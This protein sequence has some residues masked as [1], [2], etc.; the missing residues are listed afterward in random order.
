MTPRL[1]NVENDH[2]P[3]RSL[4]QS[5]VLHGTFAR[6]CVVL[7]AAS[8]LFLTMASIPEPAHAVDKLALRRKQIDQQRARAMA[9]KL[10]SSAVDLQIHQLEDNGLTEL[11]IYKEIVS[12]RGSIGEL[13]E[14]EMADVVEILLDAQ[15]LD[16]AAERE[17]KFVAA[18]TTI[19]QIVIRLAVERHNLLR[20][21]RNAEIAEQIKRLITLET[22]AMTVTKG[23]PEESQTRREQLAV[24]TIEDQRDIK[25]LFL[26]LVETL[27]DVSS[28][29]GAIG[30]GATKGLVILKR[31]EV[32]LHLD[33]AGTELA[34]TKF[35]SSAVE[36]TLVVA[37][38]KKLLDEVLHTQG[39]ISSDSESIFERI[40]EL[41]NRQ[42]EVRAKVQKADLSNTE[43]ST[44]LTTEQDAIKAEL[45]ELAEAVADNPQAAEHVQ[46]AI[47]AAAK[48]TEQI[49]SEEPEQAVNAQRLVEGHLAALQD[50]LQMDV[51]NQLSDR[52]AAELAVT[53]KNLEATKTELEAV[54]RQQDEVS[55]TAQQ[56]PTKAAQQEK[57]VEAALAAVK[58]AAA[59]RKLPEELEATLAAA[60][61]AVARAVAAA[62]KAAANKDSTK[63]EDQASVDEAIQNADDAVERA[64][65]STQE[66]LAE[67][68]RMEAAVKIGE[69]ARAAEA[70]ERAAAAERKIA[71][72]TADIAQGKAVTPEA[73]V[74]LAKEQKTV[75]EVAERIAE[76]VKETSPK[77]SEAL[78]QAGAKAQEA[79]APLGQLADAAKQ[80]DATVKA[81][82]SATA[83]KNESAM[84]AA[85][86]S[87]ADAKLK[88]GKAGTQAAQKATDAAGQLAS[89]AQ[90]LRN[91][92][93]STAQK[94][95]ELS[96]EQLAKVAEAQAAVDAT[97]QGAE[98][99]LADR[100]GQLSAA[101]NQVAAAF[102]DQ[103]RAEGRP[104]AAAA[105]DLAR[106]IAEVQAAQKT[107]D[108]A[109]AKAE[110]G[111]SATPLEAA[112][113]QLAVSDAAQ[114][115][116]KEATERTRPDAAD[117]SKPSDELTAELQK[118]QQAGAEAARQAL[119]GNA[120]Q[121][122]A[123][124]QQAR[125]ALAKALQ[126][127]ITEADAAAKAEPTSKPDKQAQEA[128]AA[129]AQA[130]SE[131][132]RDDAGDAAES[133]DEATGSAQ[134]AAKELGEELPELAQESQ[135][136]T[137]DS[138]TEAAKTLDKAARDLAGQQATEL[139]DVGKQADN[140]ARKAA[141]VDA[142][143]TAAIRDA[144]QAAKTAEKAA[145]AVAA[146]PPHKN[147][148]DAPNSNRDL[149]PTDLHAA[150]ADKEIGEN[151]GRAAADLAA[152]AQQLE[153]EQALAQ[154]LA[155]LAKSQHESVTQIADARDALKEAAKVPTATGQ[156]K[157][158]DKS[159]S[160]P[161]GKPEA[162]KAPKGEASEMT[163]DQES[164][165]KKLAQA[166]KQFSN[167]Q[168][169]TGEGAVEL[170]GQ[171]EVANQPI[172][173]ALDLASELL[174]ELK[175]IPA[176]PGEQPEQL[177]AVAPEATAAPEANRSETP[178]AD[179]ASEP[180]GE[181]AENGEP[182]G[183]EQ[184]GSQQP[185]KNPLG[186]PQSGQP[187]GSQP[188]SP[189]QG[190]P[191]SAQLGTGFVP[192]SPE[193][194]ARLMADPDLLKQLSEMLQAAMA[195]AD[196]N[197]DAAAAQAA[198]SESGQPAATEPPAGQSPST[199][200]P[201]KNAQASQK[202]EGG[203]ESDVGLPTENQ[204]TKDDPLNVVDKATPSKD[205]R[206]ATSNDRNRTIES[207]E[208]R[209]AA[210]FAK[211]PAELRNAILAGS[212][213]R[214]PRAYE[215][216]LRR[217]FESLE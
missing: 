210:W 88:A 93:A 151:L 173:E 51:A 149:A 103:Q 117:K 125:N 155:E 121:A 154:A 133:L 140:A 96:G 24:R 185:G 104:E 86:K 52:T 118:A 30:Q 27:A 5:A 181:A 46:E 138:L 127:A 98:K 180:A 19:R 200:Q 44:A 209:Q 62:L 182:A 122:E 109:A 156:D 65:A 54:A 89:A 20:R 9:Q 85:Q 166:M 203:G 47:E 99:S 67:A 87:M 152:R 12:M 187:N 163:P 21:L 73:A 2:E 81:H 31:E 13:V 159:N 142:S 50:K 204:A 157:S 146:A 177:A 198:A 83:Q 212:Q 16:T 202:S 18:R 68:Q 6:L 188:G 71:E 215:D 174:K 136:K 145:E 184:T 101:R 29:D 38:L 102:A 170:S 171:E 74:E 108:K 196:Q 147:D 192:E 56:D 17:A 135:K 115:L 15:Q 35:A 33:R 60:D 28:W 217:Y 191:Q 43:E 144:Q 143:A 59:D 7:F 22:E 129:K 189:Q 116:A 134:Q 130:A 150:D 213:R 120:E 167:S 78:K 114:K 11:P 36:Q 26:H 106:K 92:I 161:D 72:T 183:S 164:S 206:T 186:Q 49:F 42:S 8:L 132:A 77:V 97:I 76:G 190:T 64:L 110:S 63:K 113:T 139:A 141:Q 48:A 1:S 111:V 126:A 53:V 91:E 69:L 58:K 176:K 80:A 216:R 79:N 45:E 25:E 84:A 4:F 165:A 179:P 3:T 194:T 175:P 41:A 94:L 208:L 168:Q 100:L 70:L 162:G 211:L 95:A 160:K 57:A 34:A 128:V 137:K 40:E 169:L 32:G 105:M 66:S 82:E 61:E 201:P 37:G 107:A 131:L 23:L 148:A 14:T 172:R 199:S 75:Q 119:D 214:A 10:V 205:G 123:A 195:T 178:A 207:R 153:R 39:L 158:Q 197:G 193:A 124:R 90:E 112:T 55:E